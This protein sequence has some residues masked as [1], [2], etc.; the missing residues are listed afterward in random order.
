MS[1]THAQTVAFV[2]DTMLPPADPPT[3][4]AGAVK[5]LRE[6]LFSGPV[7]SALTV[8]GLLAIWYLVASSWDWLAH[9]VWNAS[10]LTECRQII[11][12]TWGEGARGA[13]WAVIRERWNQ[14]TF[15]FYPPALYWR[16]TMTFGLLL[17]ALAPVLFSESRLIRRCVLA[18]AAVGTLLA[19]IALSAPMPW[20]IFAAAT[21]F[22]A[23]LLAERHSVWLLIFSAAFPVLG[24][25]FLWGGSL[26][27]PLMVPV[28]IGVGVL[29]WWLAGRILPMLAPLA[30]IMAALLFWQFLAA[31]VAEDAEG[32]I[33]LSIPAVRSTLFGGFLLSITIGVAGIV[34]SL[35]L[36]IVLALARRSDMF[37]VKS[38][39]VM[40]I[41]FIR[42]VPL[43]TLLFVASLLL[44]YFLPPGTSFDIILRV[45]I[46][47]TLF[48]AA[49]MAE[50]IRG[51]LAALPK[52]QYEAADA[53]GLDYWKAQRLIIL[54]QALKISIPGIVSTFIGMFKD[55]TLVTFVG[56]YDPLKSMSDAVRANVEWK[57][58]YWEP[59]IFVGAV[60]FIICFGMSR[61]SM[62]LE[63]HLAR[64]HR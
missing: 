35:P 29:V 61:Y 55:T 14:Y 40:F 6:N 16:P 8:L 2:R 12:A 44:N 49:Y 39:A 57:G 3:Q 47:V 18:V 4:Q 5:W 22:G 1:E 48:S 15:G 23:L 28:A 20:L 10:S 62:Y 52:G 9:S 56:L 24:V 59:Y 21:M 45:I 19:M 37:L 25:W 27:G 33:S 34:M 50:V 31:D 13:C 36:G 42:G 11:A 30:G 54:P 7:N 53:L 43:I 58:I 26:W 38:L 60:F 17:V 32:L 51:G 64:D 41:E 46:M 63:R